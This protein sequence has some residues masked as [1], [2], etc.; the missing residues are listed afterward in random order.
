MQRSLLILAG[1]LVVVGAIFVGQGTGI[2]RGSSF[3]V[4]DGRWALI[5]LASLIV[6][7]VLGWRSWRGSTR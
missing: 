1:L 6:G 4:G 5:G 2:L 7:L 3:M